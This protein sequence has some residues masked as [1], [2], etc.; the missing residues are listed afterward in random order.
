VPAD[1]HIASGLN[2]LSIVRQQTDSIGVGVSF[3]KDSYATLDLCCRTFKR[4]EGY[5][6]YRVAG[7]RCVAEWAASVKIHWGVS[8]RMYPHFDLVRCYKNA[9]L[10]PHYN[11]LDKVARVSM[12][13]I[14][15]QFRQDTSVEW[16]AYGW[17]R[18][19][20]FSR[21]LIL[22]SCMGIDEKSQRVYPLRCWK[23]RDVQAYNA[24]R[25]LPK[26][27]SLGRKDQGGLDFHPGALRWLKENYPDDY[28]KWLVDFPFSEVQLLKPE[29]DPTV[30]PE[31][32]TAS[33]S[34]FVTTIPTGQKT[35]ENQ[36][37]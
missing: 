3:G 1:N 33:V 12:A 32:Q 15:D 17:R 35:T 19:D 10:Q 9:L 20:S 11:G 36:H 27:E 30:Q 18:N 22:K 14:E 7:L 2:L 34:S 21:A 31:E 5:Y 37:E 6:L 26:P 23:R 28:E 13:D 16:L 4:V 24:A 29:I 8:V 25:R